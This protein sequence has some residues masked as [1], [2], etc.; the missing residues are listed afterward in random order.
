MRFALVLAV[1]APL[2]VAVLSDRTRAEFKPYMDKAD[3]EMLARAAAENRLAAGAGG[4]PVIRPWSGKGPH[5]ISGGVIHDW[6][7]A[8]FVPKASAAAAIAV[9]QDVDRYKD[10][11]AP[12]CLASRLV[13]RDGNRLKASMRIVKKNVIEVVLD[14]E[15][16]VEYKRFPN[17]RWQVWSRSTRIAEIEG[18]GTASEKASPPDTGWG[19][20][21]RLNTYW[22]I[23]ERDGGVYLECRAVSLTRD[24]PFG[25]SWIIRPMVTSLPR[26]SLAATLEDTRRAVAARP[27]A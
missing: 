15:Y 16:D 10:V 17:G 26:E 14:T 25:L 11:Y 21:W 4:S 20:L 13:S 3:G 8:V 7:G 1:T 22:Q 9:L 24:I 5:A 6:I 19:F 23:E 18:A 12:A 27:P 2:I